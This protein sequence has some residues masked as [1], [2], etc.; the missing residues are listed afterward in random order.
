[1]RSR[2]WMFCRARFSA[3]VPP[4]AY[5]HAATNMIDSRLNDGEQNCRAE[6]MAGNYSCPY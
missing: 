4:S 6:S 3:L 2:A 1:M 5:M